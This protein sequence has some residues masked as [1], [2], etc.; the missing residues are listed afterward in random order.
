MQVDILLPTAGVR[1][2][3]TG[4]LLITTSGKALRAW[5]LRKSYCACIL[6][7]GQAEA[8]CTLR[9]H[10][11]CACRDWTVLQHQRSGG[12]GLVQHGVR[13]PVPPAPH[14]HG[15]QPGHLC[16]PGAATICK[17][18]ALSKPS[19]STAADALCPSCCLQ[20]LQGSESPWQ[21]LQHALHR[22]SCC[23]AGDAHAHW[24]RCA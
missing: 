18:H 12:S 9:V 1:I 7:Q 11:S 22:S 2:M 6:Q 4:M 14:R 20:G 21:H 3:L 10:Q 5:H 23:S 19:L 15:G 16:L 8:A 13:L 24:V 17:L